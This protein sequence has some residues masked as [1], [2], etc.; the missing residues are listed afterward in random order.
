LHRLVRPG[1]RVLVQAMSHPSAPGGGAFIER[2]VAPDM[3]MRPT[4][5]TV[6]LLSAPGLELR[7]VESLREH[8]DWTV[9]AW[10]RRLEERW[11]DVVGEIGVPGAR[12]WRLYLAGGGL[13]FREGRMGVDQLLFVRPLEDGASGM[14]AT[15]AAWALP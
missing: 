5:Q 7:D 2:Y 12:I 6:E 11:D 14:P 4:W 1:G 10:A 8:Y 3:H 13:T 15:R 9:A